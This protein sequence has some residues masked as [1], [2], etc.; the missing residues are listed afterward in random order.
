MSKAAHDAGYRL[1]WSTWG[2]LLTLT[3]GML[4]ASSLPW[5]AWILLVLLLG[6]M[7]VKAGF[8]AGNFMHL[9]FEKL[10]LILMVALGILATSALLFTLLAVDAARILRLSSN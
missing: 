2:I 5:P 6:A 1:Y 8:I 9:R 7:L 4:L 10:A 3:L